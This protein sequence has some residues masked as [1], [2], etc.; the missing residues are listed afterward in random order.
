LPVE[1][2]KQDMTKPLSH[3]EFSSRLQDLSDR[4]QQA[5][6]T[7][8]NS[9]ALDVKL[10]RQHLAEFER[11]HAALHRQLNET[12]KDGWDGVKVGLSE[13]LIE[14]LEDFGHLFTDA[15]EKFRHGE[16]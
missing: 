2:M 4:I 3:H 7:T 16:D 11:R 15:D 1:R 5:K 6:A 9:A 13:S 10:G 12:D 8:Q 14:L